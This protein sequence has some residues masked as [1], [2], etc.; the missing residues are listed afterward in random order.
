MWIQ[1]AIVMPCVEKL[2]SPVSEWDV[3]TE[4]YIDLSI[5]VFLHSGIGKI[6]FKGSI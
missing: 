4:S 2:G 3:S 5:L 1:A 6:V